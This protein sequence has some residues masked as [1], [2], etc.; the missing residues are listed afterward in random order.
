MPLIDA[1]LHIGQ[2]ADVKRRMRQDAVHPGEPVDGEEPV[3][4]A[5]HKEVQMI[6]TTLLQS[7]RLTETMVWTRHMMIVYR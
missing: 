4:D 5:D 2:P 1:L 3:Q 6:G 7:S